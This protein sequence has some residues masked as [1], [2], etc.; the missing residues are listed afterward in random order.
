VNFYLLIFKDPLMSASNRGF[1]KK[2]SAFLDRKLASGGEDS[3][4]RKTFEETRIPPDNVGNK[5]EHDSLV[6]FIHDSLGNSLDEEPSHLRSGILTHLYA[7]KE[8]TFSKRTRE[9]QNKHKYVPQTAANNGEHIARRSQGRVEQQSRP[10]FEHKVASDD[11]MD[12]LALEFSKL[13]RERS[14]LPFSFSM[15]PLK[16]T[17]V[18]DKSELQGLHNIEKLLADIL[19]KTAIEATI[20]VLR[21]H[22]AKHRFAVFYINPEERDPAKNKDLISALR[23]I[24]NLH[25]AKSSLGEVNILLVLANAKSVIEGHLSKIGA[26]KL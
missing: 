25:T 3:G 24:I 2:S 4:N 5:I 15:R 9:Q 7:T 10:I 20:S 22:T 19:D 12:K 26:T 18:D 8:R 17:I 11:Y 6:S 21:Y 23:Q 1:S 14:G 13:L 16:D